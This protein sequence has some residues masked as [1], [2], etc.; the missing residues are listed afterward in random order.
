MSGFDAVVVGAGPNGLAAAV[1]LAS[2]GL[3]VLV[4][5]GHE[6]IG[7]GARSAALTLPGF[8]HDV[9]STSFPLGAGSPFFSSLPLEEHGLRWVHPPLP[10]AHPLD[11]GTAVVLHRSLDE[12]ARGLGPDGEGYRGMVA[13]LADGWNRLIGD[14]LG[15]LRVPPPSRA[16]ALARFGLLAVQSARNLAETRLGGERARALFAGVAGHSFLQLDAPMSGGFG[17]VLAAA[18]HAVGWPLAAG[19]AQRLPDALAGV[20]RARGGVIETGQ[21]VASLEDLPPARIVLLDVTPRQALAL[22]KD[23]LPPSYARAL[24][25]YRYGPGAFKVDWALEAPIPWTA[26]ACRQAGVVHVGGTFDEIAAGEAAAVAGEIAEHPLVLVAQPSLFDPTRAP[27]GRHTAWGYC[28]VPHACDEEMTA[29]IEAQI[30]RF[31]PGFGARILARHVRGPA[32]LEA[33]NP[34]LVGGDING[35][36]ADWRQ[37]FTRPVARTNPYAT[38]A[39]GLYLCSA[40]TPPGGGVH[41]MCGHLAARAAL[42]DLRRGRV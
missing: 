7:G 32:A 8:V 42:A 17:L 37:F 23:R 13:L 9:C 19:G 15:P 11:D 22:A 35:G 1:T 28:H 29:R 31:A 21:P 16:L 36:S 20:L 34:N 12:T 24:A 2:E 26:E 41:G 30:E 4:R 33:Y 6:T 10:L 38:P 14:L 40:S 27:A 25:R 3:R 39:P 5:E 18:A